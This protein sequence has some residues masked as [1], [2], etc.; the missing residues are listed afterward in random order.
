MK[1]LPQA[2]EP[3]EV[4]RLAESDLDPAEVPHL[5]SG[6]VDVV[7]AD[8]RH[9]DDGDA[10]LQRQPGDA[11]LA[12]VEAAVGRAGALGVHAEHLA[13]AEDALRGGQ[14]GE[15]GVGVGPVDG[16]LA[17]GGVEPAGEPA[18][19]SGAGEVLRLGQVG[20]SAPD[21]QALV[22]AVGDGEVVTG[23]DDGASGR[24][25]FQPTHFRATDQRQQRAHED[26]LEEPIPH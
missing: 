6:R 1:R 12:L 11:G 15:R 19:E 22:E 2:L 24:N 10:G 7:G 4:Q 9:R 13:L 18:L 14:R 21:H 5:R 17:G 26:V 3:G 8:H 25:V 23:E 20:D 16:H